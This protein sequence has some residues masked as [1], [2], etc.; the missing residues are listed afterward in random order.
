MFY[1]FLNQ[2]LLQYIILYIIHLLY[3]ILHERFILFYHINCGVIRG[4]IAPRKSVTTHVNNT[5]FFTCV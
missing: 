5:K 3:C 1:K 4:F 2:D